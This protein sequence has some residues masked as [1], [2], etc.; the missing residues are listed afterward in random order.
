MEKEKPFNCDNCGK[1]YK[2]LNGLKYV[3]AALLAASNS[4]TDCS[5]QH[6]SHSLPCNPEFK[7]QAIAAGLPLT[8]GENQIL[9][10]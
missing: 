4:M 9:Q 3:S 1:R 10:S 5:A 7:L 8:I 2:N 6:K